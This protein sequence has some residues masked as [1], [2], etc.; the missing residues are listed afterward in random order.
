MNTVDLSHAQIHLSKNDIVMQQIVGK[1]GNV[2]LT[3]SSA[4]HFSLVKTI[5]SQQL[6][7]KAAS[8]IGKRFDNKFGKDIS[9][10]LNSNESE[11][12]EVGIS[13]AKTRYI[14]EILSHYNENLFFWN[15][16]DDFD[17]TQIKETLI[18]IKGVG[19]WSLD[20]FMIFSI[21]RLSI[22]PWTDTGIK[23][24]IVK[25]YPEDYHQNI[26]KLIIKWKPYESVA[27]MYLWK[28][29]DQGLPSP[30]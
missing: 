27:C 22:F 21:G 30:I 10:I 24:A 14:R 29:L 16:L 4:P 2:T 9:L 20:M 18:K 28:A 17:D 6:S 12:R 8:T 19:N 15:N 5:I 7:S 11:F 13:S 1:I 23:N 25:F 3:R 26:E